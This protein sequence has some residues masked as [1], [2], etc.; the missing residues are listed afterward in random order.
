MMTTHLLEEADALADAIAI[1]SDG[2]LN[3]LVSSLELKAKHGSGYRLTCLT[4]P[5]HTNKRWIW[6]S[7]YKL[8]FIQ[9]CL[10]N[11]WKRSHTATGSDTS[12]NIE[13]YQEND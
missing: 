7:R 8:I 1:M 3:V 2:K 5:Q 6:L 10:E 9:K 13:R 11:G 12:E 4:F